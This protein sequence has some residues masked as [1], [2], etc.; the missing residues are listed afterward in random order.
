[1]GLKK[2]PLYDVALSE[3]AKMIDFSGW[4]MPVQFSGIIDEHTAVRT[5]AGIFDVSHMG[6]F[7]VSG[8]NSVD[9][10]NRLVTGHVDQQKIGKAMYTFLCNPQGG[11][12]DDLIIYRLSD[13]LFW[14]VVNAANRPKD[15]AW[16]EQ[17][18]PVEGCSLRDVSDDTALIAL[19]GPTSEQLLTEVAGTSVELVPFSFQSLSIVGYDVLVARTGYTGEDGFEMYIPSSGAEA[20]WT[21]LQKAGAKP[22]G[23]GARD[24]L[25][26]EAALPLYGQ[27]LTEDITPLEAKLSFAVKWKERPFI[28]QEALAKQKEEGVPQKRVGL[29]MNGKRIAR[30]G[31]DVYEQADDTEPIGVV[32][33][34]T[35]SPTLGKPIALAY[36]PATMMPGDTVVVDIRGAKETATIVKL[37][38]YKRSKEDN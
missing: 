38:F 33:S 26:L 30:T 23:L 36:V 8:P 10:L 29:T 21:A 24:T 22:C 27:D 31:H 4:A 28:G 20:V 16:L 3:K 35:K 5:A 18:L 14:L 12:I 1:M 25:R 2:T 32:T 9:Y 37:P 13:E 6:E 11:I 34:G 17:H 15:W 19:Q 7:E